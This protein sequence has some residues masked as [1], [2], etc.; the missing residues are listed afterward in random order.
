LVKRRLRPRAAFSCAEPAASLPRQNGLGLLSL[1]T[2]QAIVILVSFRRDAIL[3]S[4]ASHTG[5]DMTDHRIRSIAIVGGG[6]AGWMAAA[7]LSHFLEGLH[8][9]I[10]LIESAE[11]GTVGVGEATIPPIIDFIKALGI[12]ENELIKKTMATF[13]LGIAFKDWTRIGHNYMHPFGQTGFELANVPFGGYWQKMRSEGKA[14]RLEEYNL[15][16]MAA[17]RGRFMRPV[18]APNSPLEKITYALHF[19]ASLFARF[20]RGYSEARG[21][22]R[23]EGTVKHVELRGEDGFIAALTLESGKR[24]EADLFIDCT[25]F[26]GLLIEETLKTGYEDWTRWLPCNRAV[27]V[28]CER[29]GPPASYTLTAALESGWQWRIPLQHRTGNGYVYCSDFISDEEAQQRLLGNLDGKPLAAPL[30]LRFTTGRRKKFWNKNCV[31]LGLASGFLEPLESTSIHLIHRGIAVLLRM[32]P[33]RRFEPADIERYNKQFVFEYERVRDFLLLHYTTNERADTA[34]WR[35]CRSIEHPDSL[36]ERLEVFRSYGRI[37]REENELFPEQS[38]LYIYTG[39]NI[40][41]RGYEPLA[42][43]LDPEKVKVILD[44]I[45][46][47]VARCAEAMTMHQDFID[48]NCS[49]MAAS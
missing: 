3:G 4:A 23:I 5:R 24:I 20:L 26:R 36:K 16:A 27:A 44:D 49:A 11:I 39:Q 21:V 42:D 10:R 40:T 48:K 38:W 19:D 33:D 1:D 45:R 37:Q 7:S 35:H 31:T 28:P 41:P 25:G 9:S 6:T 32:F 29:S 34:F 18:K 13:K 14:A 15:Q 12:D 47:V 22:E 2:I 43:T 17:E 46:A 30:L 8:C